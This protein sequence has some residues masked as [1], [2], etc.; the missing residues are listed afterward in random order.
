MMCGRDIS[1]L[2]SPFLISEICILCPVIMAAD[3]STRDSRSGPSKDVR[4]VRSEYLFVANQLDK[5]D[6]VLECWMPIEQRVGG[7]IRFLQLGP[8]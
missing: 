7:S 2:P 6:K 4:S 1:R 8:W 5:R 3:V